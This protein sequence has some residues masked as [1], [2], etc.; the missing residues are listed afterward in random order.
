MANHDGDASDLP[1]RCDA[2][3]RAAPAGSSGV[4]Q[5]VG[6]R[7][8]RRPRRGRR[9]RRPPATGARRGLYPGRSV[10][11][12][13]RREHRRAPEPGL[14]RGRP[15]RQRPAH[16]WPAALAVRRHDHERPRSDR[17]RRLPVVHGA[18]LGRRPGARV[19]DPAPPGQR[20]D[21][22]IVD[23]RARRGVE[24][25]GRRVRPQW[26]GVDLRHTPGR[27]RPWC[28]RLRGAGRRPRRGRPGDPHDPPVSTGTATPRHRCSSAPA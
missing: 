5:R 7:R 18:Q 4:P 19:P 17:G 26:H 25:A 10:G 22:P 6:H 21:G 8:V 3:V 16:R 12:G 28:L 15:H 9:A 24:L 27:D 11:H 20:T 13:P 1:R 14:D 23:P 2:R